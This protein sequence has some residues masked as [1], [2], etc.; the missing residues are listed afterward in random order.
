LLGLDGGE[1]PD[2]AIETLLN[3]QEIYFQL[4]VLFEEFNKATETNK[5]SR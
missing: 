3:F 5:F 4:M 1:S 2:P